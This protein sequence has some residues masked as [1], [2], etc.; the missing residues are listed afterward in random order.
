MFVTQPS[1][2]QHIIPLTNAANM[3]EQAKTAIFPKQKA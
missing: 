1:H 3:V 2:I